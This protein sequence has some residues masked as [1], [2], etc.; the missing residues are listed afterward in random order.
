MKFK[1]NIILIVLVLSVISCDKKFLDVSDEL[2]QEQTLE[3]IFSNPQD[4]RRWHRNIYAGI[5]NSM[6]FYWITITNG[7]G[8]PWTNMADEL[9]AIHRDRY[10]YTRN[11]SPTDNGTFGRWDLY[12]S[13]R[14]A[15]VFLERAQEIPYSGDADYMSVAEVE[16]LKVQARFLRAYY[17]YLLFELY[18]PIPIMTAIIDPELTEIDFARNSVDEVVDFIYNELTD[19]ASSLDDPQISQPDYLAIPT[20]GAALAIRARLLVYAASPLFNGGYVEAVALRDTQGKQLFPAADP[21]KWNRALDALQEFIDYANSGH[22][23]LYKEYT[24]GMLDADKSL[25]ELHMKY[26]KEIIFARS[27]DQGVISTTGPVGNID[28]YLL[29]RGARGGTV[30]TGGGGVLQELV[31]AF[32]MNDGLDI[33]ESPIYI[34]TGYSNSGDDVTGRTT[35]GTFNMFVNREPRFYQTVFYNGRNWHVGGETIWFNR[36]GN[37]DNSGIAPFSGH[38]IYKRASRKVYHQAPHPNTE[39]R[40]IIIHRLAEFYL[41]YAEVLNEVDPSDTRIIEYVDKIRE[42]A[43]IPLLTSIKSDIIGN[44]QLQREAIRHE[45]RIELATEGQRYFDVKRWMIAQNAP[46]KGGLGGAFTG[47]DMAAPTLDGFYKRKV[48]QNRV[49]EKRGYLFPLPQNEIQISTKLI[50]NPGY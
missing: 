35:P 13:I 27:D 25:Y 14:Q 32:Q 19:I 11:I 33:D 41:L 16:T 46:G 4:T 5:P 21:Q 3:K 23:E 50:Q 38:L 18:G 24:G 30:N 44:Q 22:Y 15:N 2:A 40:P 43:G 29:P 42:R 8:N 37:S 9:V 47:M 39:Y 6:N 12:R 45:M 34:E 36:G 20:K 26:N 10:P 28:R 48:I 49:F 17:H 1:L 7:L 31:D